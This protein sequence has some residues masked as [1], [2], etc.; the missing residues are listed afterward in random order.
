MTD[1]RCRRIV[2]AALSW[3]APQ[4]GAERQDARESLPRDQGAPLWK[5]K[6]SE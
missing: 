4:Q 2:P 5:V 6:T 3:R 1:F